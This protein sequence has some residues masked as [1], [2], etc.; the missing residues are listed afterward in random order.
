MMTPQ[1]PKPVGVVEDRDGR[2]VL[3]KRVD[4]QRHLLRRPEPAW[5]VDAEG[6]RQAEHL[7]V[8]RVEVQDAKRGDTWHSPLEYV[9]SSGR[10]F[11][12]GWGEQVALPLTHWSF[13]PG[14]WVHDAQLPL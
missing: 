1:G 2:L 9:L 11:D 5:A 12:R 13:M 4:V 7:G 6:L 3:V 14:R 10:R 8:Y